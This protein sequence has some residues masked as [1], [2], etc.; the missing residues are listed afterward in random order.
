MENGRE[1]IGRHDPHQWSDVRAVAKHGTPAAR[2]G[3]G[4]LATL[5]AGA[6]IGLAATASLPF[7]LRYVLG[8]I[9]VA[10]PVGLALVGLARIRPQVAMLALVELLAFAAVLLAEAA[11]G[12]PTDPLGTAIVATIT[13][14]AVGVA[15]W[16][17]RPG[18]VF[19]ALVVGSLSAALI[20]EI[21][22]PVHNVL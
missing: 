21:A 8:G 14:G 6:M 22:I 5:L 9:L 18:D 13:F 16:R 3:A 10:I 20:Y 11:V 12:R 19:V 7:D 15:G 17:A 4:L 2:A 1:P